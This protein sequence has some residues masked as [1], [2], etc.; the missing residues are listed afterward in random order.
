M[1]DSQTATDK[2]NVV[3]IAML[4]GT[5]KVRRLLA[6]VGPAAH[7]RAGVA[8]PKCTL[9]RPSGVFPVFLHPIHPPPA[10]L[11][12]LSCAVQF[13]RA[14]AASALAAEPILRE[15]VRKLDADAH[16]GAVSAAH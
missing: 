11:S 3:P 7:Y 9:A 6:W 13:T 10:L 8:A 14:T 15:L 2:K 12:W 16:A 1:S 5:G 4:L